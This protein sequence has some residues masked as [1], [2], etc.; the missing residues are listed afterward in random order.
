MR[1]AQAA[2]AD[3]PG[4]EGVEALYGCS[5]GLNGDAV[6]I[7]IRALAAVSQEELVP[8]D[9]LEAARCAHVPNY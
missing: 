5:G 4:R 9:P 3:G 8:A 2:W 1:R 7:F 6:V